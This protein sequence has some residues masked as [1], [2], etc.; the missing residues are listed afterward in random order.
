MSKKKKPTQT[1]KI[2]PTTEE[3][4]RPKIRGRAAVEHLHA[5]DHWK[6]RCPKLQHIYNALTMQLLVAANTLDTVAYD[7][8]GAHHTDARTDL[9][10]ILGLC[11]E[12]TALTEEAL[13]VS[14][15]ISTQPK[16]K[17][18]A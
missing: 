6:E 12:I 1:L 5:V 11:E 18:A 4:N 10:R 7:V 8:N 16:P 2:P 15:Q 17:M 9:E 13:Q 14:A 3:D